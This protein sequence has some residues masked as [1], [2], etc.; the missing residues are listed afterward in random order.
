MKKSFLLGCILFFCSAGLSAQTLGSLC[1]PAG[2]EELSMGEFCRNRFSSNRTLISGAL[3]GLG[4]VDATDAALQQTLNFGKWSY[5]L[6]GKLFLNK[7]YDITSSDGRAGGTFTPM[8]FAVSLCVSRKFS[9]RFSAGVTGAYCY[10]DLSQQFAGSSF[11]L[12]LSA[13]YVFDHGFAGVALKNFGPKVL[14]GR[15][16]NSLPAT[17]AA[18]GFWKTGCLKLGGEAEY[19][20]LDNAFMATAGLSCRI[21][22]AF[23]LRGGYRFASA[24][25]PVPSYA[26]AGFGLT[27]GRFDFSAVCLLASGFIAPAVSL[28]FDW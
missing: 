16:Y 10:T 5:D 6:K 25:A 24:S 27:S 20:F 22:K 8:D 17:L 4:S 13:E 11:C 26:S 28:S 9:D 12:G 23:S 3:W 19:L 2:C 21:F 1:I 14:V 18:G 15:H 7:P